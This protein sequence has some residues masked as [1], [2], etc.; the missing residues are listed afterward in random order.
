[1]CKK[2]NSKAYV[3]EISMFALGREVGR[4][5]KSCASAN[6]ATSAHLVEIQPFAANHMGF[7][8]ILRIGFVIFNNPARLL[9]D[10]L[11]TLRLFCQQLFSFF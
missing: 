3:V 7:Y 5:F 4:S 8:L 1:M 9:L 2:S 10:Y 11:I 6:S